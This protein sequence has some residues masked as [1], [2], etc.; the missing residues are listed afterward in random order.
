M[1]VFFV[2]NWN[3]LFDLCFENKKKQK[4]NSNLKEE[5]YVSLTKKMFFSSSNNDLQY[6]IKSDF[7]QLC[8]K[9][10]FIL[11]CLFGLPHNKWH[12][13]RIRKMFQVIVTVFSIQKYECIHVFFRLGFC[14]PKTRE[15]N[16]LNF[17]LYLKLSPTR[18]LR[19]L[20]KEHLRFVFSINLC[21][22]RLRS[23]SSPLFR[24][25][26]FLRARTHRKKK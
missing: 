2:F 5:K 12:S 8:L 17:A 15:K 26:C 25:A 21:G 11:F 4:E 9:H 24:H 1:K 10:F 16:R 20:F 13:V 7:E 14:Q 3:L 19:I 22:L 18:G 6:F 23:E